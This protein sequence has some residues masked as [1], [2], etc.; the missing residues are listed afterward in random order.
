METNRNAINSRM[1]R[2]KSKTGRAGKAVTLAIASIVLISALFTN[3]NAQFTDAYSTTTTAMSLKTQDFETQDII[4]SANGA[5]GKNDWEYNAAYDQG[6][7]QHTINWQ[8]KGEV[9]KVNWRCVE[10]C[11]QDGHKFDYSVRFNNGRMV[12][13]M[14]ATNRQP[15]LIRVQLTA[16]VSQ[17]TRTGGSNKRDF[18]TKDIILSANGAAGKNDWEYNAAYGQGQ[19]LHTINWQPNGRVS[20]VNWRCVDNCDK[21]GHKFDYYIWLRNGRIMLSMTAMNRQ[22]G[23][24]RVELTALVE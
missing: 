24:I 13:A 21:D 23:L 4:L 7:I 11:S 2:K 22:P 15:G 10:N 14:K 3:G 8:P 16:L 19:V 1:Q 17:P 20:K 6:W 5:A 18:E 12:L 9:S